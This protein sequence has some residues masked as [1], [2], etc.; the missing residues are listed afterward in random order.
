M[1]STSIGRIVVDLTAYVS[2][3]AIYDL[4]FDDPARAVERH[5]PPLKTRAL[6]RA[7]FVGDACSTDGWYDVNIDPT[8]PWILYSSDQS[9]R[10]VRFTIAHELG[11]H[12]LLSAAADLL[13]DL[14]TLR[15]SAEELNA[16]EESVCHQFAGALLVPDTDITEVI[17]DN[18]VLPGHIMELYRH[19]AASLEA[20]AIRVAGTMGRPGAVVIMNN[21]STIG[22]CASS[23]ELGLTWWRRG[24]SVDPVGPLSRATTGELQAVPDTYR[25]GLAYS[26]QLY[27]DTLPVSDKLAI[28]VLCDRPSTNTRAVLV[29][30]EPRW[31]DDVQM[32]AWCITVERDVGWCDKC[33]G[34]R[35][36][37]CD[38]CGCIA[39]SNDPVCPT[40][41]LRSPRRPG[42]SV[43]RDCE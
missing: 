29:E 28:A 7:D 16:L 1:S 20:I 27:C 13:D 41:H 30:T 5:F 11:H 38:K 2:D 15:T 43:C 10:R 34:Q 40:C 31:K 4:R 23:P 3:D 22:F 36:R 17:G 18:Q 42:A 25:Y 26:S 6:P 14:D 24:S 19:G 35:C 21:E 37:R 12:L 9:D 8:R 32:C 33:K 39:P